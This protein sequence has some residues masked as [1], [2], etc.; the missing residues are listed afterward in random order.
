MKK[1]EL[2]LEQEFRNIAIKHK[3]LIIA[4]A[5]YIFKDEITNNQLMK[6]VIAKTQPDNDEEFHV[7][8][9]RRLVEYSK[10]YNS[11]RFEQVYNLC[12]EKSKNFLP[13]DE[14]YSIDEFEDW[15]FT[16]IN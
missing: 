10:K 8:M 12:W 16:G 1:E 5:I 14:A 9:T 3:C 11:D 4:G 2:T 13:E 15:D 6:D 7:D